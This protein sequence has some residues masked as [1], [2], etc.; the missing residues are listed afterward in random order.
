[1]VGDDEGK[2]GMEG[3]GGEL[4]DEF[5]KG[6]MVMGKNGGFLEGRDL[7]LDVLRGRRGS[8]CFQIL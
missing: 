7:N 4:S 2:R 8:L 6:V 1:M 5:E 3:R